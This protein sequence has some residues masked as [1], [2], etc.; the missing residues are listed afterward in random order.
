M[1]AVLEFIE[2]GT[3]S[4]M[5]AFEE[6]RPPFMVKRPTDSN[7]SPTPPLP[8]AGRKPITPGVS[9]AKPNTLRPFKG[10]SII[11]LFSTTPL[12]VAEV[13]STS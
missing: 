5:M 6:S 9:A 3:P 1:F 12:K 7:P 2:T 11:R 13:V 10:K 8:P 4:I